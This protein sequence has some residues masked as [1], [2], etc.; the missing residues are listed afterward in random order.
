MFTNDQPYGTAP[1]LDKSLFEQVSQSIAE[2]GVQLIAVYESTE[3]DY[4]PF[5]YTIGLSERGGDE[6]IA[7]ADSEE[8]LNAIAEL[9]YRIARR[10]RPLDPREVL[11]YRN[12][13]LTLASPDADFDAFLQEHCLVE[14]RNYYR[15]QR[16]DVLVAL[17]ESDLR[18]PH[19]SL[20]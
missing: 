15:S 9:L 19:Q 17:P 2:H 20:H 6:I 3:D 12:G 16:V 10:D 5:V 7:F 13:T 11:R 1:E 8:E 4:K 18:G 14:A